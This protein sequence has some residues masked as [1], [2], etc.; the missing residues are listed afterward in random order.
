M[1]DITCILCP[2]DFSESSQRALRHAAAI[3]E[4]YESR[5]VAL[6]VM[7]P[8]L[9]PEAPMLYARPPEAV[10][11]DLR[12]RLEQQ[13]RD[14]LEPA[15]STGLKTEAVVDEGVPTTCILDRATSLSAD[16]I[17]TGTHGRSG[18]DR[19][20]L[21]SVAEKVLR[22]ATCPVLT[23][24]PSSHSETKLPYKRLLC[25]VDFS[26][27]SLGALRHALS[28][29]KES[30]AHVTVL[31]ALDWPRDEELVEQLNSPEFRRT[32]EARAHARLTALVTDEARTWCEPETRVCY[33]KPYRL[34]LET[35]EREASDLIVMGVRGRNPLDLSMFGST[36]NHVVRRAPCPVL[37][38][39]Q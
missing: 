27:S 10:F 9:L 4:W 25:P 15:T 20:M 30:D 38:W 6:H 13:L 8:V 37:T 36:T 2:V 16:L 5:I 33:G 17:V 35:A 19:F 21:G 28:I 32:L 3:A 18:F 39:K 26:E 23:V 12:S 34:I 7:H 31:H 22:K 14:W 24:P 1:V 11:V 29:A